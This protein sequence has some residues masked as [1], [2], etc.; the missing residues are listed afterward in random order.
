SLRPVL[1]PCPAPFGLQPRSGIPG[2]PRGVRDAPEVGDPVLLDRDVA[3]AHRVRGAPATQ[4]KEPLTLHRSL[5]PALKLHGGTRVR[6][7]RERRVQAD[8]IECPRLA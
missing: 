3:G 1:R 5:E 7:S 6:L 8:A 4:V 2:I